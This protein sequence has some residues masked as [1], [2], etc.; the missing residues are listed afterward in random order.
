MSLAASYSPLATSLHLLRFRDTLF[1][2]LPNQSANASYDPASLA[3]SSGATLYTAIR[4]DSPEAATSEEAEG[5]SSILTRSRA[6]DSDRPAAFARL[7]A[8]SKKSKA[9]KKQPEATPAEPTA[10]SQAAPAPHPFT[11]FSVKD[12]SPFAYLDQLRPAASPALAS[13]ALKALGISAWSPPPHPR[14]MRG[15]IVYL[16]LTTLEGESYQLTAAEI[17]RAH[18]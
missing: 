14:R 4:G 9:T 16:T 3:I 11:D 6:A 10:E 15:D 7:A 2:S 18:V 5:A 13:P 1:S 17:G 12:L 8:D